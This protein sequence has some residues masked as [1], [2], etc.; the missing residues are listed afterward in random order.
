ME[1]SPWYCTNDLILYDN[2]DLS[3]KKVRGESTNAIEFY[4]FDE[5]I[6][7]MNIY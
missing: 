6:T 2:L 4:L 7:F 1:N 5:K 3:N